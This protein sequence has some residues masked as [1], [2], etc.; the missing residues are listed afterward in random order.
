MHTTLPPSTTPF[1]DRLANAARTALQWRLLL[2][3]AVLLLLPTLAATLPVSQMLGASFD[4]SPHAGALAHALD[5]S[6]VS[7]LQQVYKRYD[8][9][10][11]N[12]VLVALVLTLLMSPLLSGM[13]I[14]AARTPAPVRLGF[15]GLLAGGMREY[16]RLL[17]MLIWSAVPLALAFALG[18]VVAAPLRKLGENALLESTAANASLAATLVIGLFL[19]LAHATIDAGRAVLAADRRKTSAVRAWSQGVMLVVR[20]PVATLGAYVTITLLGLLLAA[21]VAL[22]RIRVAPIEGLSFFGALGLTQVAVMVVAWMRSARLLA[23]IALV[24]P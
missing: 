20:R 8:T 16:G 21:L 5:L 23:L 11:S 9:A 3:W 13:T 15:G 17:R 24:R 18:N 12:G 14:A 10:V 22:V 4:Y 2:L 7:D 6:V 19:L 1:F